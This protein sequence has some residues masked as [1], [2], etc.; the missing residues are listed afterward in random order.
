V[1]ALQDIM[2]AHSGPLKTN[3]RIYDIEEK[4]DI[5]MPMKSGGLRPDDTLFEALEKLT[6]QGLIYKILT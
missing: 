4:I 2:S 1:T 6:E 3:F 5:S